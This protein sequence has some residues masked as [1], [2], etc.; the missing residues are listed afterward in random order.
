MGE[1]V[2]IRF[3]VQD[4]FNSTATFKTHR[5]FIKFKFSQMGY[6]VVLWNWDI[7]PTTGAW[8][9]YPKGLDFKRLDSDI[10]LGFEVTGIVGQNIRKLIVEPGHAT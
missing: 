8:T 5:D 2:K 3:S 10:E 7:S 4:V 6:E 9:K 1:E